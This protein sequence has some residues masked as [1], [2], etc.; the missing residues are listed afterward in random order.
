MKIINHRLHHN[1][2]TPMHFIPTPNQGGVIVPEH[3]V[4]HYD[5][6]G[7]M[8]PTISHTTNPDADA[9]YHAIISRDA[10]VVQMV[11]FN[12]RAWHAGVSSWEGRDGLNGFSIGIALN[13][14]GMLEPYGDQWRAW[15]GRLYSGSEVLIATHKNR[16]EPRGW[17]LYTHEQVEKAVEL[18][19]LLMGHYNLRS[20]L[21]HEDVA[22]NRKVDPGP[23]FPM[24]EIQAR[25]LGRLL[26]QD[27]L[28]KVID[29][30]KINALEH[31]HVRPDLRTL[32]EEVGELAEAL[33]GDHEHGPGIELTQI[34]GIVAHWLINLRY[35]DEEGWA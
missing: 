18:A 24:E 6:S 32:V 3:V 25:V 16:T 15:W 22:P 10:S 13:N 1:D 19:N 31:R 30:L 29:D 35:P 12:K 11:P 17:H 4:F 5:A 27:G 28:A 21:G 33:A 23:A 9:S 34:G 14:A 20:I 2:G 8:A 7:G 26:V